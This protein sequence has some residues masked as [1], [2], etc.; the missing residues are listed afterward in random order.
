MGGHSTKIVA[1]FKMAFMISPSAHG[2][3][4]VGEGGGPTHVMSK[5]TLLAA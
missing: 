2:L 1:L 4:L 3:D 5:E